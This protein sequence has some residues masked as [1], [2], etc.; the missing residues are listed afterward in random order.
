MKVKY[1]ALHD[2]APS[3]GF[4]YKTEQPFTPLMS[5]V[6]RLVSVCLSLSE[7]VLTNSPELLLKGDTESIHHDV[8]LL[9]PLLL[10]LQ[11][12]QTNALCYKT[13]KDK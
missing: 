5:L 3:S 2:L 12:M 13:L 8:S 6:M 10:L 11:L 1:V 9:L 7:H 4:S